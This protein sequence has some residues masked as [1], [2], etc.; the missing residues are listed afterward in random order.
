MTQATKEN[1]V[2]QLATEDLSAFEAA[3]QKQRDQM[4]SKQQNMNELIHR[5]F[6][7]PDGK[8]LMGL[9]T[10]AVLSRPVV[11]ADA[12]QFAA[13]IREGECGVIR[14]IRRA[15]GSVENSNV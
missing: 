2:D 10:E 4:L 11:T 9:W 14:D 7:T 3:G 1:P 6:S 13:G 8:Q 5:V 15:I 12:T